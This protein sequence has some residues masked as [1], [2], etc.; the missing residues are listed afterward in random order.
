[1]R[2]AWRAAAWR[3]A[4][5]L[6]GVA[7]FAGYTT[8]QG[9]AELRA[10]QAALSAGQSEQAV[11]HARAAAESLVPGAAHVDAAYDQLQAIALDAERDGQRELAASAWQAIRT[12]A[13][14]SAHF[15]RRPEPQLALAN[16]NLARLRGFASPAAAGL[17]RPAAAGLPR[18][19]LSLSFL[20]ALG[21]LSWFCTSAWSAN[22]RWRL[23][24]AVWPALGWCASAL[25]LGWAL[26]HA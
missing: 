11:R 18:V 21:A 8:R 20:G 9:A 25:V 17:E 16:A 10:A 7:A 23:A 19:L 13:L 4:L 12:A 22:G 5:A 24:R 15:W 26:L 3:A 6:L 14:E 1:L 2:R